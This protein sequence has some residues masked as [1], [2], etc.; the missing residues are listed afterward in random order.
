MVVPGA[1]AGNPGGLYHLEVSC[2]GLVCGMQV[3]FS[4]LKGRSTEGGLR[5]SPLQLLKHTHLSIH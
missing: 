1:V 5:K 4:F 3:L 2:S